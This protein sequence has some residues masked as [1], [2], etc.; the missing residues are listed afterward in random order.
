LL[1]N[2]FTTGRGKGEV[3]GIGALLKQ[4]LRKEQLKPQGLKIQNA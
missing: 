3:D 2:Y 4:K 1:W